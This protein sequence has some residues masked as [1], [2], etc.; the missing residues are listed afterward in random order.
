[1]KY[2][3]YNF[4]DF[5]YELNGLMFEPKTVSLHN[6]KMKGKNH[7]NNL[8]FHFLIRMALNNKTW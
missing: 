2:E 3:L 8:K 7:A 4:G 5:T 6:I 1:M